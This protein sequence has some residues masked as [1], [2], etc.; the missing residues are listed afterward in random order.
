M[1]EAGSFAEWVSGI[2]TLLAVLVAMAIATR[3]ARVREKTEKQHQ[4]EQVSAWPVYFGL[5][6]KKAFVLIANNSSLPV[7]DVAISY[8]AAYGAGGKYLTGSK[9]N[10]VVSLVP[11]G[12]YF[13]DSP[14]HPGHGM[15]VKLGISISFR[16]SGGKFWRRDATGTLE[17]IVHHPFVANEIEQ[18][19]DS[20]NELTPL[21][22]IKKPKVSLYR[23]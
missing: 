6:N 19:I 1:L 16:D 9:M 10:R 14:K 5:R 21:Q 3:D 11:P 17:E 4:A 8:G 2:G 15:H 18:P 20:W 7:Y 13:I 12:Q 23:F 22:D